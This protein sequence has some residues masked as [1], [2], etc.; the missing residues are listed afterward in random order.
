MRAKP[1]S[2]AASAK[3]MHSISSGDLMTRANSIGSCASRSGTPRS[4]SAPNMRASP[5]SIATGAPPQCSRARSAISSAQAAT[6]ASIR[7]PAKKKAR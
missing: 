5:R 6:L 4:P 2:A 7:G 3:F 1:I